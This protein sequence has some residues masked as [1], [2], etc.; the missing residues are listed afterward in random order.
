MA[1]R[2]NIKKIGNRFESMINQSNTFY[3]MKKFARVTKSNEPITVTHFRGN[4]IT[5]GFFEA[6]SDPDYSG[7]LTGGRAVVFEA[8]H[9]SGTSIPFEQVKAHQERELLKH[10]KLGAESF[11]LIGFH[12]KRFYRVSIKDWMALKENIGKK[13]LNEKDLS[14]YEIK[15][16]GGIIDYLGYYEEEL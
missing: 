13:S 16:K 5:G 12:F 1:R 2:P 14:E 6:K 11:V 4:R 7:T 8:K 9:C 10:D 15:A 3:D